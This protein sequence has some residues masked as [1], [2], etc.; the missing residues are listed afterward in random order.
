MEFMIF[1]G[2]IVS[3]HINNEPSAYARVEEITAD[4][5]P[6]WFQ[7]RLLFLGFPTQ[8][9]TWILKEDYLDGASFTMKNVPVQIKPLPGPGS[10]AQAKTPKESPKQKEKVIS[11]ETVRK[12]K[13]KR[14]EKN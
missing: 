5:K 2:D 4:I 8:E 13:T 14:P 10:A 7:V 3:I 6:S 9:V 1:T 12:K 11:L